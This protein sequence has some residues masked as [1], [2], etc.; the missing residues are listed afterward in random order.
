MFGQSHGKKL[1]F[2]QF[3]DRTLVH[4]RSQSERFV[5]HEQMKR[6]RMFGGSLPDCCPSL[7]QENSGRYACPRSVT[8]FAG[9]SCEP[10]DGRHRAQDVRATAWCD[11]HI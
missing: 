7:L 3:Q 5:H 8:V 10:A 1:I 11:N 4:I 9:S 2:G 6:E